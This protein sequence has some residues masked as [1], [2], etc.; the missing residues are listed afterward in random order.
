MGDESGADD[1]ECPPESSASGPISFEGMLERIE[2]KR[3]Q[4]TSNSDDSGEESSSSLEIISEVDPLEQVR[5]LFDQ[6]LS[7]TGP[8]STR[9]QIQSGLS[10]RQ[11]VYL[12]IALGMTIFLVIPGIVV[13]T[14]GHVTDTVL[15]P[16]PSDYVDAGSDLYLSSDEAAYMSRI[17]EETNHEVAFCGLIT[18]GEVQ[19]RLE[20]WMAD[21]VNAGPDQ[22]EFITSNCPDAA[23]EVLLHTHPNGNLELSDTD[24]LT[25]VSRPE[26][27]M[28]VQGGPLDAEPGE[29]YENLACYRETESTDGEAQF[30]RIQVRGIE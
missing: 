1:T 22:V 23:R 11:K 6:R 20:I 4:W 26:S 15:A 3:S 18:S 25:L 16:P 2:E 28:C 13:A 27:F 29:P 5:E 10:R 12:G 24:K 19:P 30:V 14:T 7:W 17:F 9:T 21:T 8:D